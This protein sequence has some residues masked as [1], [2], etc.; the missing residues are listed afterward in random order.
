MAATNPQRRNSRK[1]QAL[2]ETLTH[3]CR[4]PDEIS[5]RLLEESSFVSSVRLVYLGNLPLGK[6]LE[7]SQ[8]KS[9]SK[10]NRSGRQRRS[11]TMLHSHALFTAKAAP[12]SPRVRTVGS[13][14]SVMPVGL[15]DA[16]TMPT[17]QFTT[18]TP[19]IAPRSTYQSRS[20]NPCPNLTWRPRVTHK[21]R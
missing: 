1:R 16:E 5:T 6:S 2:P 17:T 14:E 19:F 7:L 12:R 8:C 10:T 18:V 13:A 21:W 9:L 4:R 3:S 20:S 11:P 15:T